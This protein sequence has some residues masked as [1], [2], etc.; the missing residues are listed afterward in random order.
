[1]ESNIDAQ[2]DEIVKKLFASN[3]NEFK[4]HGK[5]L[6]KQY[7]D[8]IVDKWFGGMGNPFSMKNSTIYQANYTSRK[9]YKIRARFTF[10]SWIDTE[11]YSQNHNGE[12][13]ARTW[14]ERWGG[15]KNPDEYVLDLQL[16]QGIIGLPAA[17]SDETLNM[18]ESVDGKKH[19]QWTN[20]HF[21][22]TTPLM[23]ELEESS[24]N[25]DDFYND[26]A[27]FARKHFSNL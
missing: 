10:S 27:E 17:S 22:Q 23:L 26:M 16:E 3:A 20:S 1:M 4:E 21:Q 13:S 24:S 8:N 14:Q 19:E 7:R 9:D 2:I 6:M 12:F 11:L 25:W 18:K 15:E 5:K